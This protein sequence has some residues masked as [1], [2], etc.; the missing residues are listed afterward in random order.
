MSC[1]VSYDHFFG[2]LPTFMHILMTAW[3][4]STRWFWSSCEK[5]Q[6]WTLLCAGI[7]E[8]LSY[9]L[10]IIR[11]VNGRVALIRNTGIQKL[12]QSKI[13]EIWR[14]KNS[15]YDMALLSYC[16]FLKKLGLRCLHDIRIWETPS[17]W[18]ELRS[19]QCGHELTQGKQG[20]AS[21][22]KH[23]LA[24]VSTASHPL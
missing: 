21:E 6:F 3:F 5:H 9:Q 13:S 7:H 16:S 12:I 15:G 24:L 18:T 4:Y 20:R 2:S 23:N 17:F 10:W 11:A 22:F 19:A 8:T 14:E 1:R